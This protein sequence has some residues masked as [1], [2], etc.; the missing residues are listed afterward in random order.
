VVAA[1]GRCLKTNLFASQ[2][3]MIGQVVG[4]EG[5]RVLLQNRIAAIFSSSSAT[6]NGN[7]LY[8]SGA[9]H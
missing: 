1:A 6:V 9:K 7:L 2:Q 3:L 8:H 5:R 4:P